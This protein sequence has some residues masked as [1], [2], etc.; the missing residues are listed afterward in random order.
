MKKFPHTSVQ[1]DGLEKRPFFVT[2]RQKS[3][4]KVWHFKVNENRN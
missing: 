2:V 4:I 1:G 3:L